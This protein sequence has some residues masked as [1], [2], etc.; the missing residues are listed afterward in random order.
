[1]LVDSMCSGVLAN[2]TRS[3]VVEAVVFHD[4]WLVRELRTSC[5][6]CLE[7]TWN[8]LLSFFIH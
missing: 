4:L 2:Y 6:N 8:Y 1:M 3:S 5:V 7:A